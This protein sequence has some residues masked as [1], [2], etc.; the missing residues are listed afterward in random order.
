MAHLTEREIESVAMP[1]ALS[2]KLI[3]GQIRVKDAARF[4]KERG[5]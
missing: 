4:P 3:P 5:L 1:D 2:R